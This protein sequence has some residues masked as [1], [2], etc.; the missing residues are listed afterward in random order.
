[1][2]KKLLIEVHTSRIEEGFLR[3]CNKG[4][5]ESRLFIKLRITVFTKNIYGDK[6]KGSV[7]VEYQDIDHGGEL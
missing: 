1:M 4:F 2:S 6:C 5:S 7:I 3:C